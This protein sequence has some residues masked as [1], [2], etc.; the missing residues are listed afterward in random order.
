MLILRQKEFADRDSTWWK[1]KIAEERKRDPNSPRLKKWESQLQYVLEEEG[2]VNPT[3]AQ[4]AARRRSTGHSSY[5]GNTK[6]YDQQ[7]K[8][9]YRD[10]RSRVH[11]ATRKSKHWGT[12]STTDFKAK[13]GVMAGITAAGASYGA[14]KAHKERKE[15]LKKQKEKFYSSPKK[16]DEWYKGEETD[17]QK[18]LRKGGNKMILGT[19]LVVGGLTGGIISDAEISDHKHRAAM[20]NLAE[21]STKAQLGIERPEFMSEISKD[22]SNSSRAHENFLRRTKKIARR[23]IP[24]GVAKGIAVGRAIGALGAYGNNERTK[25]IHE[26]YNSLRRNKK[27][28]K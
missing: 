13:M 5:S 4:E 12:G 6:S 27:K 15:F 1:N 8:E 23:K 24:R 14:Y 2:K 17:N 20:E 9:A 19:G 11:S 3:A 28:N 21:A 25:T 16:T 22:L 26:K 7:V 18:K 10:W